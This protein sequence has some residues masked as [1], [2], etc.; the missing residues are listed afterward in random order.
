MR[1]RVLRRRTRDRYGEDGESTDGDIDG[2]TPVTLKGQ[3][4]RWEEVEHPDSGGGDLARSRLHRT[5]GH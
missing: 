2:R 4:G 1:R 5:L 3:A